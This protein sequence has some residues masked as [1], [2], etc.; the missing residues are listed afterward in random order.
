MELKH[1]LGIVIA[2]RGVVLATFLIT[3]GTTLLLT[4]AQTPIYESGATYVVKPTL[5]EPDSRTLASAIEVLSRGQIGQTI[6]EVASSHVIRAQTAGMLGLSSKQTREVSV[7]SRLLA[8]TNVVE[9]TVA[10]PSPA[11]A[12]DFAS[13]VGA[14][15]ATF[16]QTLYGMYALE[17]LD[18]PTLPSSP[19]K[20][21]TMLNLL[22]GALAG[23]VLGAGLA[24][25]S[26]YLQ[27]PSEGTVPGPTPSPDPTAEAVAAAAA[28]AW[29]AGR[30]GLGAEPLR[31]PI[32]KTGAL[33]RAR[34]A[35]GP[36][37][38]RH[39]A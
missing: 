4:L 22:L 21:R 5:P 20:P 15:T 39:E 27:S 8:G 12:R 31:T 10:G 7:S 6:A 28:M 1:Y 35:N 11:L 30:D 16:V 36:R 2:K 17:P 33:D 37:S 9:I 14:R 32:E 13:V 23:L 25:L 24:F 29:R 3:L 18:E 38:S 19:S 26:A 34:P